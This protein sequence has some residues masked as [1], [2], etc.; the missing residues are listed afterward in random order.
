MLQWQH[1]S[2]SLHLA[3]YHF[4][5]HLTVED[6][7]KTATAIIPGK[8]DHE[9]TKERYDEI[10]SE[11]FYE[12]PEQAQ[13]Y[14][15]REEDVR[16][17]SNKIFQVGHYCITAE[18]H[19][20]PCMYLQCAYNSCKQYILEIFEGDLRR[21]TEMGV[22]ESTSGCTVIKEG[23]DFSDL[24]KAYGLLLGTCKLKEQPPPERVSSRASLLQS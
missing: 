9:D 2:E 3:C 19:V 6:I 17:F 4:R 21:V 5:K 12:L 16:R 7:K 22:E 15:C 11:A 23:K 8:P 24:Q 1:H 20:T 10:S 13:K 18:L 14:A